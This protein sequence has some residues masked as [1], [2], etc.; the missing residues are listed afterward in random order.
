MTFRDWVAESQ[1]EISQN[2]WQGLKDSAYKFYVGAFRN[3]GRRWNYGQ[4]IYES[5]WD[6]LIVLD[7]CRADLMAEVAD[8][9]NFVN[10]ESVYSVASSSAEWMEKNFSRT[11]AAEM[12]R[13]SYVTANP[14]SERLLTDEEFAFLDEV[15]K[16]AWDREIRTIPAEGVT[17]AA[18]RSGRRRDDGRTIVH[19][20]QPHHPFVT[21][22]MDKGLPRDEFSSTPWDNVWHKLRRGEVDHDEVWAAYAD[23][24]R[25]VLDDVA[26]L[27]SNF[28]ADRAVITADHANLMGEWGLYAHPDYVPIR[29]LKKVPWCV[30]TAEDTGEYRVETDEPAPASGDAELSV[31]EQLEHLGYKQ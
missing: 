16:Y 9:Y 1:R 18:I 6:L 27:L 20:M 23:N 8:E 25:Y 19:Y 26:V 17:E 10:R 22:P 14:Y 13:T 15:W 4:P 12:A 24:L 31:D 28:D 11:F 21:D 30:T 29:T 7:A 5:E 3:L 2:G